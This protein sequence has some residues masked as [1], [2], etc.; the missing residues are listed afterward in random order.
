MISVYATHGV[1]CTTGSHC[2]M[3]T[4]RAL[5][6]GLV[7][8]APRPRHSVEL[9]KCY[10]WAWTSTCLTMHRPASKLLNQS[11]VVVV[12]VVVVVASSSSSKKEKALFVVYGNRINLLLNV[13]P[14]T[15]K[16]LDSLRWFSQR[17]RDLQVLCARW[18]RCDVSSDRVAL[19]TFC[20]MRHSAKRHILGVAHSGGGL[21]PLNSNSV[22][23]FAQCTYPPSLII[24]CL[25]VRKLSCW[26]TNPQTNRRRRKH[27][28]FF[29]TLRLWVTKY[30]VSVSNANS[31]QSLSREVII[32]RT[33]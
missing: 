16:T 15:E 28:T 20:V 7:S 29:A 21:W 22:E 6:Y 1:H 27:P 31:R 26:H 12:V 32:S 13:S 3:S 14:K 24:L 9:L 5:R 10:V 33:L 19:F 4:C 11:T 8:M 25:F 17:R 2:Y 18:V 30:Y 23:I